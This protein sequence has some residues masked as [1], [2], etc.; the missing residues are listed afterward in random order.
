MVGPVC[1][2]QT[3]LY[4]GSAGKGENNSLSIRCVAPSS[5]LSGDIHIHQEIDPGFGVQAGER[6]ISCSFS[7]KMG[8]CGCR[9]LIYDQVPCS[10]LIS[11]AKADQLLLSLSLAS[12]VGEH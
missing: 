8:N 2:L 11:R 6:V 10:S 7:K 1:K 5:S 12:L 3:G 9:L 4:R